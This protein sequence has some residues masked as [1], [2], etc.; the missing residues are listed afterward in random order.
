M[1][2]YSAGV[3]W[4]LATK[5]RLEF[6]RAAIHH[7]FQAK[8]SHYRHGTETGLKQDFLNAQGDGLRAWKEEQESASGIIQLHILREDWLL[9]AWEES[10]VMHDAF[11]HFLGVSHIDT[12]SARLIQLWAVVAVGGHKADDAEDVIVFELAFG[13]PKRGVGLRQRL[14]DR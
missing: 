2:N 14:P 3:R 8:S 7:I 10:R 6:E 9:I 13:K 11:Q 5:G 1:Q 12:I 4:Q